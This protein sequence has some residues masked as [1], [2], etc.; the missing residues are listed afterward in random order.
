MGASPSRALEPVPFNPLRWYEKAL[1]AIHFT[2]HYTSSLLD[3][4]LGKPLGPLQDLAADAGNDA[5]FMLRKLERRIKIRS[6]F[7]KESRFERFGDL[8]AEIR[9]MIWGAVVAGCEGRVVELRRG[10]RGKGGGWNSW[11]LGER[12]WNEE[13]GKKEIWSIA[14]IPAPLHACRQ[15]RLE[16][17]KTYSLSFGADGEEG[18]GWIDFQRDTVFFGRKCD[19]LVCFNTLKEDGEGIEDMV[20]VRWMAVS[21]ERSWVLIARH[22]DWERLRGLKRV[23]VVGV[24]GKRFELGRSPV[25][26]V[27][28][29]LDVGVDGGGDEWSGGP[30][31]LAA[32]SMRWIR[33]VR[34]WETVDY[35]EGEVGRGVVLREGCFVK[36]LGDRWYISRRK[37]KF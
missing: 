24:E 29:V 1:L 11:W 34:Q 6:G 9:G 25:L 35:K 21:V 4:L 5:R 19:F 14:R 36:A 3:K 8:P 32:V 18:K 28:E 23:V 10:V 13:E 26:K 12:F 2:T 30:G 33:R 31:G 37:W 22:L 7:E 15:S 20:R 27:K 17:M 16:A